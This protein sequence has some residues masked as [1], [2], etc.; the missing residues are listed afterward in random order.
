MG[1]KALK[2]TRR[3]KMIE[4]AAVTLENLQNE[5]K[6]QMAITQDSH[7]A[8]Q[9]MKES[10]VNIEMAVSSA[11]ERDSFIQ[12]ELQRIV[13]EG[14]ATD[15]DDLISAI[16]EK[17]QILL[18][19]TDLVDKISTKTN[20][21]KKNTRLMKTL[22]SLNQDELLSDGVIDFNKDGSDIAW[23]GSSGDGTMCGK[24]CG[25]DTGD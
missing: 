7:L 1:I 25:C 14:E 6:E 19:N 5:G 16:L 2:L 17:S 4:Q 20:L 21:I 10:G 12:S 24:G 23:A 3:F 18:R 22:N 11:N 9:T 8:E 13:K 15:R